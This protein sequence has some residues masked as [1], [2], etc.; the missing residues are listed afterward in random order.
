MLE[1]M[2]AFLRM[3]HYKLS[4]PAQLSDKLL[5]EPKSFLALLSF[6]RSCRLH[7]SH[8]QADINDFQGACTDFTLPVPYVLDD[9]ASV[10]F[11]K[12]PAADKIW[13]HKILKIF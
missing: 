8:T 6:L 10:D 1:S 4:R 12:G 7:A 13:E 5:L 11:N 3:K 2:L 9:N